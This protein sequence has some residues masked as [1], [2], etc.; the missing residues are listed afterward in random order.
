MKSTNCAVL[1]CFSVPTGEII[2]SDPCYNKGVWCMGELHNVYCGRWAALAIYYLLSFAGKRVCRLIIRSENCP[3]SDNLFT[4]V[5]PFV[6]GVDSGRAGFFD[7]R[8]FQAGNENGAFCQ[9]WFDYCRRQ[10]RS[11]QN[12]GIITCGVVAEAGLGDGEYN[13]L[14][15]RDNSNLMHMAELI[16]LID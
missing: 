1:G 3:T 4:E 8:H 11:P 9:Y 7:S 10:T 14:S 2:V 15:Y 5:A 16:F 13:C 12:A 6:I